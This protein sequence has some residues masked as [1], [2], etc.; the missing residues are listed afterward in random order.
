MRAAMGK[1]PFAAIESHSNVYLLLNV[2]VGSRQPHVIPALAFPA[3][4]YRDLDAYCQCLRVRSH[5]D[6][7]KWVTRS[8]LLVIRAVVCASCAKGCVS[9]CVLIVLLFMGTLV[10]ESESA[11][12]RFC[13]SYITPPRAA[14]RRCTLL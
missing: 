6:M 11:G 1:P 12:H 5:G 4:S 7:L 10:C 14:M 3:W 9:E 8:Q 2:Q 13:F